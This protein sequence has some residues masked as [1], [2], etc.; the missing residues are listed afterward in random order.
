M[1]ANDS[2]LELASVIGDWGRNA[3]I[4]DERVAVDVLDAGGSPIEACEAARGFLR[5]FFVHPANRSRHLSASA[6]R[7]V[8]EPAERAA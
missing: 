4:P 5:G 1:E 7:A 6:R 2:Q 3:A 8:A